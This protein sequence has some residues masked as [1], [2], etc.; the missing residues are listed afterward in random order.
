M[1]ISKQEIGI[2]Q[3]SLNIPPA[4][5][6][7][8]FMVLIFVVLTIYEYQNI[9]KAANGGFDVVRLSFLFSGMKP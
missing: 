3:Y 7:Q 1:G 9:K 5:V 6:I 8:L 4:F 2:L